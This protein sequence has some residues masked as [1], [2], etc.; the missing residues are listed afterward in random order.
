MQL[1]FQ[2]PAC[3]QPTRSE[4]TAAGDV[5][6]CMHCDWRRELGEEDVRAEKPARCLICGCGDLWRQ[7]DFPQKLG[8]LIVAAGALLSTIAWA[9]MRPLLALGVLMAFALVDML[10]YAF[11]QDVLVCYRCG[12]RHRHAHPDASYP[13]FDLEV[14]ERYRQ[15]AKRLENSAGPPS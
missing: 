3:R 2:C 9:Y 15:E 7:K 1:V 8:L 4:I 6:R 11:M 12:A 10:L 5:C 14:A 13:A